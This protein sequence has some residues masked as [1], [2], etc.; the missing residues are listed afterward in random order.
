LEFPHVTNIVVLARKRDGSIN[1]YVVPSS[2]YTVQYATFGTLQATMVVMSRPLSTRTG[3]KWEDNIWVNCISP[4]GPNAADII[5]YLVENYTDESIDSTTFAA[6]KTLVDPYKMGFALL[7]R[8]NALDVI[9][10]I[11]YQARCAVWFKGGRFYLK[12]LP[13]L[14]DPVDTIVESDVESGTMEVTGTDTEDLVT[15]WTIEWAPRLDQ[16]TKNR[17]VYRYHVKKYGMVEQ[18]YDCFAFNNQK[19]VEKF[20]LFW[21][22]RKANT[23]KRLKFSTFL[24]KL[25]LEPFDSV[26]INFTYPWVNDPGCVNPTI[27]I[28]E[29]ASY[30][31]DTSRVELEIWL[32][33]RFG[34]MCP[35]DFAYPSTVNETLIFP[36]ENDPGIQNDIPGAGATG[37]LFDQKPH[38][39][40]G[41]APNTTPQNFGSGGGVPVGDSRDAG[42]PE[43]NPPVELNPADM[44]N[45]GNGQIGPTGAGINGAKA[46]VSQRVIKKFEPSL[47]DLGD[48]TFPGFVQKQSSERFDKY[49]VDVYFNGLDNP[50]KKITVT[51]LDIDIEDVI[52]PDTAAM[53]VRNVQ[54]NDKGLISNVTVYN[55]GACLAQTKG[56]Q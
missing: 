4:L 51:Q 48:G 1:K 54:R 13:L 17:I 52:P 38:N 50:P 26:L 3:E 39:G 27:G 43:L 20:A 10:E 42:N 36:Q 19:L 14:A 30:N 24:T 35:Y 55:A 28:V 22:I 2:Y 11:A 41:A 6:V 33:I 12:Y 21:L 32:P 40:P 15:K 18:T 49:D 7:D 56:Q 31:S 5:Q 34:E 47:T 37:S 25:R 23:W 44:V 16:V 46:T 29:K 53:V 8:K 45:T 9:K